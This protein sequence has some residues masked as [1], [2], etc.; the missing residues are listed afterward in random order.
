MTNNRIIEIVIA[1]FLIGLSVALLNPWEL[2]MPNMVVLGLLV[3][4]LIVFAI[5]A[6]FVMGE[7]VVDE[8]DALHRMLADRN[9]FLLGSATIIMGVL[10]EAQ[11]HTVDVWLVAALVVMVVAKIMTRIHTDRNL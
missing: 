9:A 5:Y 10:F 6:S 7:R 8:R 3:A 2:W 1:L 11:S 4:V